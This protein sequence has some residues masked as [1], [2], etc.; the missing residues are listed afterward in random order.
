[1]LPFFTATSISALKRQRTLGVVI[2]KRKIALIDVAVVSDP[3]N[4]PHPM[5]AARS[6]NSLAEIE[7]YICNTA[8]D[9]ASS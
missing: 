5:S 9:S 4:L 7:T 1:M 3:A 2:K 8:S 6:A